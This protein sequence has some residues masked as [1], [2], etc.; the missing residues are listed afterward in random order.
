MGKKSSVLYVASAGWLAHA[1]RLAPLAGS[2]EDACGADWKGVGEALRGLAGPR[3]VRVLLSA[4]L[5]RFGVLPWVSSLAGRRAM[6]AYVAEALAEDHGISA[7][8]HHFAIDWPAFGEPVLAAAYPRDLVE[9][10]RAGLEAA[11]H[12]LDA[13]ESTPGPVLRRYGARLGAGPALLAWAE[14]DGIAAVTVEEN[15]VAQIETLPR[16]GQGLDDLA[17]WSARKQFIFADDASL[18][19]L[20]TAEKPAAFPGAIMEVADAAAAVSAGHALGLAWR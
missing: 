14:E 1:D 15:R 2:H 6:L 20:A 18:H 10:L 3:R 11:G 8:T 9:A 19:W 16:N 13:V 17:V 12:V 4:R 7:Q 5:C